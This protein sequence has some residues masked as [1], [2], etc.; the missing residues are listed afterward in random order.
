MHNLLG[1]HV[2]QIKC[3]RRNKPES[4]MRTVVYQSYRTNSVPTWITRCLESVREW[5]KCQGFDYVFIDDRLF[6]YAP[7]W[8][9]T[10]VKDD[11]LLIS[12]LARLKLA[13]EFLDQKYQR[14]IW[15]D[16][17]VL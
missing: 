16:A 12:D 3:L 11:I 17:D 2:F 14:T 4:A 5:A 1:D 13:K 8:Y 15:V 10:K 9:R 6:E 7:Q